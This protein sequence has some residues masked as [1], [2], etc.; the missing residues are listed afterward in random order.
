MLVDNN[1]MVFWSYVHSM[2]VFLEKQNLEFNKFS[3]ILFSLTK[4][5]IVGE[6]TIVG[7][8]KNLLCKIFTVYFFQR[9][10]SFAVRIQFQS[11]TYVDI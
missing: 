8:T 9:R 4:K 2:L 11:S 5:L 6:W 10:R 1:R 3:D 7:C